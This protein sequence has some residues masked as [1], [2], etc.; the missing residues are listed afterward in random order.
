MNLLKMKFNQNDDKSDSI[1]HAE[2]NL[3]MLNESNYN[4][5][6]NEKS[7]NEK[8]RAYV[9]PFASTFEIDFD[10][11]KR[12]SINEKMI[13]NINAQLNWLNCFTLQNFGLPKGDIQELIDNMNDAYLLNSL[14]NKLPAS[15]A[16]IDIELLGFA[17]K[18]LDVQICELK[19]DLI[20]LDH[21]ND[22]M[23]QEIKSIN[24]RIIEINEN[25]RLIKNELHIN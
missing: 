3:A 17:V 24:Q 1:N 25:L 5:P 10:N 6:T 12:K 9:Y 22:I 21:K 13:K 19:K 8:S 18:P 7:I 2:L 16:L 15:Y 20:N 4:T 11:K 23:I 14:L